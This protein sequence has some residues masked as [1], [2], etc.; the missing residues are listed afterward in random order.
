MACWRVWNR[1]EW[2]SSVS[3]VPQKLS[4]GHCHNSCHAGTWMAGG[5]AGGDVVGSPTR[6]T[7]CRDPSDRSIPA[8]DGG[9]AAPVLALGSRDFGA[10]D[11]PSHS[12]RSGRCGGLFEASQIEP[13]F[14]GGHVG[15]IADPCLVGTLDSKTWPQHSGATGKGMARIP[16]SRDTGVFAGSAGV[17]STEVV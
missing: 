6:N 15:N 14:I 3:K 11:S 7:G 12:R 9:F 5:R 1:R 4:M 16:S 17:E 8:G 2:T 10:G 13:A